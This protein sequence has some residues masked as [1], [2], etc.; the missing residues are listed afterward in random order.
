MD[1]KDELFELRKLISSDIF[2]IGPLTRGRTISE[3]EISQNGAQV[4]EISW[5]VMKC[6]S[7]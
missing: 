2:V 1:V 7:T 4:G 5:N 3:I 6:N